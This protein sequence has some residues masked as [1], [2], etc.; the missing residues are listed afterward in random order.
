MQGLKMKVGQIK[1]QKKLIMLITK[2]M[3]KMMKK[4]KFWMKMEKNIL[5]EIIYKKNFMKK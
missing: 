3:K 2:R 4:K 5:S 1:I